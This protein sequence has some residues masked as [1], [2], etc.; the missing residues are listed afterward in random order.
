MIEGDVP[1]SSQK[2][3][4]FKEQLT[5]YNFVDSE[6]EMYQRKVDKM[7]EELSVQGERLTDVE[8]KIKELAK[9]YQFKLD[10][11]TQAFQKMSTLQDH[12]KQ[13]L[14]RQYAEVRGKLNERRIS[15]AKTS[16]LLDRHNFMVAQVE[17]RLNQMK[18]M[19]EDK[20]LMLLRLKSELDDAQRQLKLYR[21]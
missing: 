7:S 5:G 6:R 11:L 9:A 18:K 2:T 4:K 16:D 13:E 21:K 14:A 19:I 10:R 20:D 1:V 8:V 17:N 15:E 3:V 12:L